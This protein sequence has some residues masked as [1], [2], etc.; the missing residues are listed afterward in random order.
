MKIGCIFD[1]DGTLIDSIDD[2]G[3]SCNKMLVQLGFPTHTIEQYKTFV[4]DGVKKLVERALPQDQFSYFDEALALFYSIYENE[5]LKHTT[6]FEGVIDLLKQLKLCHI[7]VAIVSNKPNELTQKIAKHLFGDLVNVVYGQQDGILVKP[8]PELVLRAAKELQIDLSHSFYI[9]DSDVDILTA[10]NSTMKSIGCIWGNRSKEELINSGA[11]FLAYQVSDIFKI[12]KEHCQLI[13]VS[14]CLI[15]QNCKWDG[16]N[17][18]KIDV[19]NFLKDYNYIDVCPEKLGGLSTPRLPSEILGDKIINSE[20]QE[21]TKQFKQ[22]ASLTLDIAE[23]YN[24]HY[25]LFKAKSPSCGNK[26]VY[27]GSFT[28]QL[29]KRAGISALA[30]QNAKIE[31]YNE[32]ELEQLKKKMGVSKDEYSL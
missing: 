28:H 32:N 23:K 29:V 5:C 9:G 25:A 21:V 1:L 10:K 26:E 27:D 17:N 19:F 24:I 30:L 11:D 14:S 6:Y 2:L 20:N 31:V 18:F 3:N 4:G 13:L 7:P 8:H 15:G 16:T 22:G 12:V